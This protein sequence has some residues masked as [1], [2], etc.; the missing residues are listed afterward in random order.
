MGVKFSVVV[1]VAESDAQLVTRSLPSWLALG[2]VDVL[3]CVDSPVSANLRGAID[4]AAR[5]DLRLRVVEVPRD[6]QWLFHQAN[7]RRTGFR[8]A[9]C[10]RILTGDVD[11]I[12]NRHCLKALN[13]V[14]TRNI[15]IVSLSK[16]RGGGTIGEFVR[17]VSKA[18][19]RRTTGRTYFTGLYALYRPYWLDSEVEEEVM[20]I[21]HPES[22]GF[23]K[24]KYPYRGEDA[25]LRDYMTRKHSVVYLP[26]VG[27]T[28][29]RTALGDRAVG[30]VKL[31]VKYALDGRPLDYVLI[32][33]LMY[34]R[35]KTMGAYAGSMVRS[36][37]TASFV[38]GY[39]KGLARIGRMALSL[40]L[41]KAGVLQRAPDVD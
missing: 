35:G 32:R 38:M 1:D 13:L 12:P 29:L 2:S 4:L 7:V 19:V 11:V 18:V 33:S 41:W 37:G 16:R 10:D 34:A 3:V 21:P 26:E 39:F 20:R 6:P 22:P 15:G 31:G 30:Q 9:R 5:G 27:G 40:A 36:R 14:G 17:N 8:A 28:D 24:G 25:I 23:E